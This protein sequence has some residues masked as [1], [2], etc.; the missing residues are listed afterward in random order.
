M[1]FQRASIR[2]SRFVL[3]RNVI[4]IL[5]VDLSGHFYFYIL[6]VVLF[7]VL[8]TLVFCRL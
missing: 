3:S 4:A 7:Y 5:P 8:Y 2:L 1:T 6:Y